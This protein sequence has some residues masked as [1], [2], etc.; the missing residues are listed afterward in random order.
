MGAADAYRAKAAEFHASAMRESDTGCRLKF[1]LLAQ[2]YLDLAEIANRSSH[3]DLV[4]E[5]PP[6]RGPGTPSAN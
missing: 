6:R 1:E 3:T 4:Y 2:Y 5:T